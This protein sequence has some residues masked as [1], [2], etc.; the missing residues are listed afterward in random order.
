MSATGRRAL[1]RTLLALPGG[2]L[3]GPRPAWAGGQI[4]EPLADSVRTALSAAIA[5]DAPPVPSFSSTEARLAY[6]RWLSH[7]SDR[8]YGRQKDFDTRIGFLQTLWY[9]A[10]RAVADDRRPGAAPEFVP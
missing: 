8:L 3:L 7:M 6:L 2:A 5:N 10:R 9:E 1:L 4:E